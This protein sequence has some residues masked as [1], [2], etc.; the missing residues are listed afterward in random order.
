MN[1]FGMN[2]MSLRHVI[3]QRSR[4][5]MTTCKRIIFFQGGKG[6]IGKT[7]AALSLI[8]NWTTEDRAKLRDDAPIIGLKA[9]VAGRSL[10]DVALDALQIAR[11][12]LNARGRLDSSG[13]NESHF[14]EPLD[15]VAKSGVTPAEEKLALFNGE[16]AG[17]VMPIYDAFAY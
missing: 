5:N 6:G 15:K 16:W 9:D 4:S 14:L 17:D 1:N 2:K 13:Q 11:D 3:L 7:E 8:S 10:Q 12:G